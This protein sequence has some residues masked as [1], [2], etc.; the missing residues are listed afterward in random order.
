MTRAPPCV[1]TSIVVGSR[2]TASLRSSQ[3]TSFQVKT[4]SSASAR[5]V[6]PLA[7][8]AIAAGVSRGGSPTTGFIPGSPAT[9]R[10]Q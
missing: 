8:P 7:S 9:K 2:F 4:G 3:R 10:P 1:S 5:M 6:S